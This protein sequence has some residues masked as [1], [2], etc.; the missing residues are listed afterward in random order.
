MMRRLAMTDLDTAL[1]NL[2]LG[3]ISGRSST[4]EHIAGRPYQPGDV[5]LT[6]AATATAT[7]TNTTVTATASGQCGAHHVAPGI[8]ARLVQQVQEVGRNVEGPSH[9]QRLGNGP[10]PAEGLEPGDG[11]EQLGLGTRIG[12]GARR[13]VGSEAGLLLA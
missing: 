12:K 7:A 6:V 5:T 9:L 3:P 10:E 4:L 13:V 1:D 8:R 2:V 11:A